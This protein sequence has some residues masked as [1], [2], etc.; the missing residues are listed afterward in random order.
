MQTNLLLSAIRFEEALCSVS[1]TIDFFYRI[2]R[3][4]GLKAISGV[5]TKSKS[6]G[7]LSTIFFVSIRLLTSVTIVLPSSFF[8]SNSKV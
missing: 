6:C 3:R 7:K 8:P 1:T 2:K 4:A 5:T